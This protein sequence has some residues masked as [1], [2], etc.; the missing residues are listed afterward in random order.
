MKRFVVL[1]LLMPPLLA[2][3]GSELFREDFRDLSRWK[4]VLFPKIPRHTQY[5][6]LSDGETTFLKAVSDDSASLLVYKQVFNPYDYPRARWRW[7]VDNVLTRA[8]LRTKEGDDVPIR[9]YIAFAYDPKRAGILERAQYEAVRLI[10]G[11]Y[12]P[13]SSL[14]YC[15]SSEVYPRDIITSAYTARA[16]MILLEQGQAKVGA[17]VAEQVHIIADYRRA[18]GAD[19]PEKATIGIMNDSDNTHGAATSYITDIAVF[20]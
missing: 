12:P 19:P 8:D 10:Y 18:F 3:S 7:K 6:A 2:A 16:K 1:C 14:T 20:R 11:E 5:S 4:Q 9:V 13:H 17:W 15:W